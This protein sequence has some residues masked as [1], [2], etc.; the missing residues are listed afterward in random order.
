MAI[1]DRIFR[2]KRAPLREEVVGLISRLGEPLSE[3]EEHEGW[4]IELK[5][6]WRAFFISLDSQLVDGKEPS[7][8]GRSGRISI[9]RAMDFDGV[10]RTELCTLA[11]RIDVRLNAGDRYI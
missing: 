8:M 3:A 4:D 11:A 5:Q 2:R 9:A 7:V 6:K 1:L 10:G